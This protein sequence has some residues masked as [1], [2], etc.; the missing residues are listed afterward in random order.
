MNLK[1]IEKLIQSCRVDSG[2]KS[3]VVR[4]DLKARSSRRQRLRLKTTTDQLIKSLL[5]SESRVTVVLTKP[6]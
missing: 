1:F 2:M 3:T 6:S 5:T 4:F